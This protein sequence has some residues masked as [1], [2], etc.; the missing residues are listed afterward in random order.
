MSTCIT[1]T[2]TLMS[3]SMLL[4]CFYL[5]ISKDLDTQTSKFNIPICLCGIGWMFFLYQ[6]ITSN[7][8]SV[9]T[10]GLLFLALS[11]IVWTQIHFNVYQHFKEKLRRK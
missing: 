8:D 3:G 6:S 11:F 10:V 7:T 1:I 5:L 4:Y 2:T 9:D